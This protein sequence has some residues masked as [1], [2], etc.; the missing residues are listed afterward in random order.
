MLK[1]VATGFVILTLVGA[2]KAEETQIDCRTEDK[3]YSFRLMNFDSQR[4]TVQVG[5]W[6]LSAMS[7]R[8]GEVSF[9]SS[10]GK[11]AIAG[12]SLFL[13]FNLPV[14]QLLALKTDQ[15]M[16]GTLVSVPVFHRGLRDTVIQLVNLK[17]ICPGNYGPFEK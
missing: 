1:S 16:S 8:L 17:F 15:K 13:E 3:S 10:N 6:E 4:E 12:K 2:L 7:P 9:K 14:E 11:T 5:L